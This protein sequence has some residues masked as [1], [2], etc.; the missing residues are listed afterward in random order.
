MVGLDLNSPIIYKHS[1]LR[2]FT[3]GERHVSRFSND[4][5]L[6]LVFDGVL[7][8][9][10]NGRQY[11]LHP[12]EYHIQKHD[13]VQSGEAISDVPKYF[14]VHF[15]GEWSDIGS[16]LHCDGTFEYARL[17]P[18]IEELDALAHDDAPYTA[19]A[20]KFYELLTKLYYSK[21]TVTVASRIADFIAKK[22]PEDVTLEM[23][24]DEFHFSKNHVINLFKKS[25]DMTP[26]AYMN[27]L[28]MRQA[29]YLIEVTS[30]PLENIALRCG[31]KNYSH[32]YKLFVRRNKRSPELWRKEK[33]I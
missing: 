9:S 33:R 27:N 2:F 13:T 32:F 1:S 15:S 14:Y 12:G 3:E 7:R 8:F 5:I 25:F 18:I 28:R 19:Q 29:E 23:L 22:L 21:P 16:V 11:E 26:V 30:D 10:E 20:G 31:F 17:K 6:L 4:D 24:C